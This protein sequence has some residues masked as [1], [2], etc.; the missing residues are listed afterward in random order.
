[1]SHPLDGCWA[2]LNR[3][4]ETI[5]ELEKEIARYFLGEPK[6]VRVEGMHSADNRAYH[7]MAYE[8]T[9][10]PIRFSVMAGEVIHHLRSSLDHAVWAAA[11]RKT[12][13]PA[14]R[15]QF[16]ICHKKSDFERALKDGMLR[17]T[18][19]DTVTVVAALQPFT[20]PTPDD[21]ILAVLGNLD[22]V[23]KH[24]LLVVTA[25]AANVGHEIVFEDNPGVHVPKTDVAV[26]GMSPPGRV[27]VTAKGSSV[28]SVFFEDP[29]PHV[30]V[31][32]K[33]ETT[34]AFEKLGRVQAMPLIEGLR[35]IFSGVDDT[36]RRFTPLF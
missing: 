28:F 15:I 21:T 29:A 9:S 4:Q 26:T 30:K 32:A 5:A 13:V 1:M 31:S 3:A 19:N 16:P 33:L 34:L 8:T 22:N 11:L 10:P 36:L 2:K 25:N 7:I 18:G 24:R 23:D 27:L 35:G 14:A 20:S 12:A 6:P 17:G